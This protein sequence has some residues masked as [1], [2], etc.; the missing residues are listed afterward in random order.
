VP[1]ADVPAAK[2]EK[3]AP[4]EKPKSTEDQLKEELKNSLLK[5]LFGG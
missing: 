4:E 5:G 2:S 1:E 3:P